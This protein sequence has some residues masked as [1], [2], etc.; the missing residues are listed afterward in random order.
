MAPV[1]RRFDPP[2][3]PQARSGNRG[4]DVDG[5]TILAANP[6]AEGRV[7]LA[8]FR[9]PGGGHVSRLRG[10]PARRL[11]ARGGYSEPRAS[12]VWVRVPRLRWRAGLQV[13]SWLFGLNKGP[14][15][16]GVGPPLPLPP[17]QPGA[18]GGGDRGAGDRPA[19]KD[20]WSNFDP[21]GLERAAKAARELEHSREC[22]PGGAGRP[23]APGSGR[24]HGGAPEPSARG[25]V[26]PLPVQA[27]GRGSGLGNPTSQVRKLASGRTLG[28][29]P[30]ACRQV[31]SL[32]P[33]CTFLAVTSTSGEETGA[34][35]TF[36]GYRHQVLG[37]TVDF[38]DCRVP[39]I[40][41]LL[42]PP[43]GTGQG[44][45]RT[46]DPFVRWLL[47]IFYLTREAYLS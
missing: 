23:R 35:V 25:A 22:G 36:R 1:N 43:R 5:V 30:L 17:A 10:G 38:T 13:M 21:T 33:F 39:D 19:P 27:V 44:V 37:W 34:E 3:N 6:R 16:E 29:S 7:A 2:P 4:A 12:H 26:D 15:G 14:K 42:L 47:A 20:K 8:S 45:A 9:R 32:S 18:E 40:L 46:V 24:L 31:Q 28:Q 11:A 41:P